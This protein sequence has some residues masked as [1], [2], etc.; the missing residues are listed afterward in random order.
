MMMKAASMFTLKTPFALNRF[1]C[2]FG[3]CWD[4]GTLDVGRW[5]LLLIV[6]IIVVTVDFTLYFH[7]ILKIIEKPVKYVLNLYC[8]A[9]FL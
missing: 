2:S 6:V 9:F 4:V 5:L 1:L 7:E 8:G 3:D